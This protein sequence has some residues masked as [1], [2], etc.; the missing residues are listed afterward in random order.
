MKCP[1]VRKR[2]HVE[3]ISTRKIEHQVEGWGCHLIVKNCDPDFF[4]S[5]ILQQQKWR[6]N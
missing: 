2:E 4:L 6:R 1:T 3:S 5:K